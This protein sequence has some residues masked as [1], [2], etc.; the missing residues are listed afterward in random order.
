MCYAEKTHGKFVLPYISSTRSPQQVMGAMVK[1]LLAEKV[2]RPVYH[3]TVMPCY[4][5]KL[6]ASRDDF[7]S[8]K[9]QSREVD[10]VITASELKKFTFFR[11]E[12]VLL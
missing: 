1:D 6:E 5:K 12:N 3:V 11:L 8:S 9:D 10:C 7:V 2:G 4:D